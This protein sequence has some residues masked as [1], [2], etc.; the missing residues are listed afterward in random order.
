M[1][2]KLIKILTFVLVTCALVSCKKGKNKNDENLIFLVAATLPRCD[3]LI[4]AE[5]KTKTITI[6]GGVKSYAI[7]SNEN[8]T[9]PIVLTQTGKYTMKSK[10]GSVL[11]SCRGSF[12]GSRTL[13]VVSQIS[14]TKTSNPETVFPTTAVYLNRTF[15]NDDQLNLIVSGISSSGFACGATSAP[16]VTL[17][18]SATFTF[19]FPSE[20]SVPNPEGEVLAGSCNQT[21]GDFCN[22]W[23]TTPNSP[24]SASNYCSSTATSTS[25][26]SSC[27]TRSENVNKTLIATCIYSDSSLGKKSY[28]HYYAPTFTLASA[29][30]S[31][32][33]FKGGLSEP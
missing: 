8:T 5:N 18:S 29:K 21:S 1:Y 32:D 13:A 23:F 9:T 12:S 33:T 6:P 27:N 7:C 16:S 3:Y 20:G 26:A 19:S 24:L 30:S 17:I 28:R 22:D 31:C 10:Q 25:S 15:Q 14:N 11:L 4:T 2:L